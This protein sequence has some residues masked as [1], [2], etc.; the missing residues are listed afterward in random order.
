MSLP[1]IVYF[2]NMYLAFLIAMISLHFPILPA[3]SLLLGITS[4]ALYFCI[5][6][7]DKYPMRKGELL[8]SRHKEL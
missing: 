2:L 5:V 3:I 6:R 8:T 7:T 4:K 1:K